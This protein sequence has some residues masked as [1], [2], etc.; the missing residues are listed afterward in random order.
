M[1]KWLTYQKNTK[2]VIQKLVMKGVIDTLG[3]NRQTIYVCS[4]GLTVDSGEAVLH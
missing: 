2:M 4:C 1:L 3:F